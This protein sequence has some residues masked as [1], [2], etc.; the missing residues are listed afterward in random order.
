[1][2][3]VIV[4]RSARYGLYFVVGPMLLVWRPALSLTYSV[5]EVL[6]HSQGRSAHRTSRRRHN[7]DRC[8]GPM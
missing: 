5:E 3:K 1:M 4:H 7:P 6:P 8:L 2:M